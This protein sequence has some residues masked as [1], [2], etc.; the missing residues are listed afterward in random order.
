MSSD[1]FT[2]DYN[3]G[4]KLG[5]FDAVVSWTLPKKTILVAQKKIIGPQQSTFPMKY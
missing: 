4:T 5:I 3:S 1:L 2:H